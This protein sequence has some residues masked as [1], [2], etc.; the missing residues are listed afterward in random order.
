MSNTETRNFDWQNIFD[1]AHKMVSERP[2]VYD[3]RPD[4]AASI[5]LFALLV[6]VG[7]MEEMLNIA[8]GEEFT[9]QNQ[10]MYARD[11]AR[12][13]DAGRKWLRKNYKDVL[14]ELELPN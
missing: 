6:Q 9:K 1:L 10:K 12:A 13:I 11:K 3:G 4:L 8:M 14:H 2:K 7:Y 5:Y